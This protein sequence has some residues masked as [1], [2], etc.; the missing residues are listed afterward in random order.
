MARARKNNFIAR[1]WAALPPL[2][3]TGVVV[4]VGVGGVVVYRKIKKDAE[5]KKQK[6]ELD[7]LTAQ[8]NQP[9]VVTT[10]HGQGAVVN[11]DL[12]EVAARLNS[13][14]NY[15]PL[16]MF[17]DDDTILETLR[18]IPKPYITSLEYIYN[19]VYKG[20]LEEKLRKGMWRLNYN[21]IKYLFD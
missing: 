11:L 1:S 8:F 21:K 19:R 5:A 17:T 14:L 16:G 7:K 13:A 9:F 6:K 12:A 20:N 3:K 15:G 4:G 18:P 2:A 10:G